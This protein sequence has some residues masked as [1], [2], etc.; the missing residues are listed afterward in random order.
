MDLGARIDGWRK[1]RGM[2]Q[3]ELAKRAGR[4]R[5]AIS[6]Y[7]RGQETPSHKALCDIVDALGLTMER[8]YGRIPKAKR[9]A[10]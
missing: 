10:A 4:S 1:A 5:A 8:F 7:V 2:T 3:L 6:Y 9:A